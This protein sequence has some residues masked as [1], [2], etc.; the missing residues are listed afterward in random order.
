MSL[1]SDYF[2][3]RV[4]LKSLEHYQTAYTQSRPLRQAYVDWVME[5][6]GEDN[7]RD[8]MREL[9]EHKRGGREGVSSGSTQ[10]SRSGSG[11]G[12]SGGDELQNSDMCYSVIAYLKTTLAIWG[13]GCLPDSERELHH[14]H[15][16]PEP[17][18]LTAYYDAD[19]QELGDI[20][21]RELNT[22]M[23]LSHA[24]IQ[25]SVIHPHMSLGFPMAP[26]LKLAVAKSHADAEY[27]LVMDAG[28]S[29]YTYTDRSKYRL[30]AFGP[31]GSVGGGKGRGS[32]DR[33]TGAKYTKYT[34]KHNDISTRRSDSE[35]RLNDDSKESLVWD[36]D[37][38]SESH[39]PGKW[40]TLHPRDKQL[41]LFQ[42]GFR[43]KIGYISANIKAK[44]TAFMAMDV[45]RFHNRK[46]FEVHIY[47]TTKQ[48]TP[49]F[50]AAGMRGVD[51]RGRMRAGVEHFHEVDGM[52]VQKLAALI[53]SHGIHIALNWDGYSNNGVR[54]TGLFPL[55]PAPIQV[56]HQEYIG[57]MGA[58]Y[59]QYLIADE[60]AVPLN[61]T[62]Y[63]SERM[64][65][66]PHSFL[67]NSFPYQRPHMS[68]PVR[69][70]D[71]HN[72]PQVQ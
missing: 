40:S 3:D 36:G 2:S 44:S 49:Q 68:D 37:A 17:H 71:P 51:W 57:T 32:G 59:I 14:P 16:H 64:I 15:P 69:V 61:Y 42:P 19:M 38:M 72:N 65:Y 54:A 60:V 62:Q 9:R 12:R 28:L 4:W 34:N 29:P 66:M 8:T 23:L 7:Y 47:A 45:F 67:A 39:V 30:E 41:V 6:Y 35:W 13:P 25:A 33:S 5:A 11:S 31:S 52:D 55:Q 70:Y 58:Q 48:D 27:A 20:V 43:I 53:H 26:E 63:Y 22:T 24:A 1:A 50:L 10:V 56:A 21:R 18:S 46:L